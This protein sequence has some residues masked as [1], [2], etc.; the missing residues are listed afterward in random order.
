[1]YN[2]I[3]FFWGMFLT[4]LEPLLQNT[5]G[6]GLP[7]T[8]HCRVTV[9]PMPATLSEGIT[10]KVG[11]AVKRKS[12]YHIKSVVDNWNHLICILQKISNKIKKCI[13]YIINAPTH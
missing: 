7:A 5:A 1:M 9:L 10:I 4:C 8:M 2:Y 12:L 13:P 11:C 3:I 6:G